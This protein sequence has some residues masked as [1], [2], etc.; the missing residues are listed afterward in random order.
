M[1]GFKHM[2]NFKYFAIISIAIQGIITPATVFSQT[3]LESN[4]NSGAK[5]IVSIPTETSYLNNLKNE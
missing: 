4:P 5:F 1:I 3:K 2:L